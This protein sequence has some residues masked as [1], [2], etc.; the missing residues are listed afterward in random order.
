VVWWIRP[1]VRLCAALALPLIVPALIVIALWALPG[2]PA[3][4]ICPPE[5]CG[6]G[7][8]A[9]AERFNLHLGRWHFYS[10]WIANAVT[11]D[12]GRSWRVM[13]GFPVVD[14]LWLY[15]PNTLLLLG[16]SLFLVI[17]STAVSGAGVISKRLDPVWQGIGLAPSVIL[18]LL[19]AAF[20]QIKYGAGSFD[21]FPAY[22]RIFLGAGVLAVADGMLPNSIL[23]TRAVFEEE[24]KQ[25]YVQIAILRGETPVSNTLPNVMPALIGQIRARV[26]LLLSGTVIVEV[27][28]QIPGVGALLWDGTL[29]QDFGVV[30]AA[31][32][33]FALVSAAM[34]LVQAML[35]IG[36]A[37]FIRRA[38]EVPE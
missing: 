33:V 18:A 21:G 19:C 6:E 7:N 32:W 34:L 5:I 23:G 8:T 16:M 22:L 30:L 29:L 35:E 9:L 3:S 31:V 14:L 25:R 17:S 26:L 4:I 37:V 28:L 15:T 27:V 1:L 12:L 24:N 13:Q 11:G 2:D 38:P 20:V 36:V 10:T